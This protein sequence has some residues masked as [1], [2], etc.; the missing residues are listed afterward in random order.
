M[1]YL[2]GA[3]CYHGLYIQPMSQVIM[4]LFFNGNKNKGNLKKIHYKLF[5]RNSSNIWIGNE[6]IAF[7][8][9]RKEE[10][11]KIRQTKTQQIASAIRLQE[12]SFVW[13]KLKQATEIIQR[14]NEYQTWVDIMLQKLQEKKK[15]E[16]RG[17]SGLELIIE[18]EDK[19][20]EFAA[21]ELFMDME[22]FEDV[23]GV[24]TK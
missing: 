1:E 4:F 21:N 2:M 23:G 16:I 17:H 12:W 8:Y 24:S 18:S 10:V 3:D 14:C 15:V 22:K 7:G 9:K 20:K 11:D 5:I 19:F 13:K 6:Y